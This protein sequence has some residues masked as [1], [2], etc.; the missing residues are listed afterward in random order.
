MASCGSR[1]SPDS[2]AFDT[3][4]QA[5]GWLVRLEADGSAATQAQWRQWLNG[6]ARRHAV[7]LRL[8]LRWRQAECLQR[9]CP[10]DGTV[11]PDL[12]DS[13]PGLQP[14]TRPPEPS[15]FWGRPLYR[16]L[17]ATLA[18]I[19][20]LLAAWVLLHPDRAIKPDNTVYHTERGVLE[21]IEL[22]DGS[23]AVLNTN[24]EIRLRFTHERR[25]I[26]LTRGEALFTVAHESRPFEV[27]AAGNT[28]RA[29]GTSFAV[30]IRTGAEVGHG[31]VEIVVTR[32]QVA[33]DDESANAERSMLSSG[34]DAL[35]D[36]DGRLYI[37]RMNATDLVHK[38]A[39]TRGE[40]WLKENTVA[41][42]VA[43]F[44]RYNNRQLVVADPALG[45]LHVGGSFAAN[46]PSAFIAALAR[47]AE[48]RALDGT[49]DLGRPITRLEGPN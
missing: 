25:D 45:T 4:A 21:H 20:A 47:V 19:S 44:N 11:D 5:A 29:V 34:E 46:D 40:I 30:R 32:G 36:T 48:V 8:E 38:L 13:F 33:V 24:S 14:C 17:A 42:A 16:A 43:E 41:E 35:V 9:L 2:D 26:L 18:A 10:L 1:L 27:E 23:T 12:L 7:Y 37:Q 31:R 49:D 15:A 3:E 22:P 28:V 39:W 6:D